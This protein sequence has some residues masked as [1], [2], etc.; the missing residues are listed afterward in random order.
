MTTSFAD[1]TSR[2]TTQPQLDLKMALDRARTHLTLLERDATHPLDLAIAGTR[3]NPTLILRP[4]EGLASAHSDAVLPYALLREAL[5][6][7]L[8]ARIVELAET[9]GI[10]GD[11]PSLDRLQ[12]GDGTEA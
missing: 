6:V 5:I 9:L 3:S 4:G 1:T 11:G 8:K 7:A 12:Y 2:Q 10:P